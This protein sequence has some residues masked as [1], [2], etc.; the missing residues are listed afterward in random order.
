MLKSVPRNC[1]GW[2][3]TRASQGPGRGA[4]SLRSSPLWK[5]VAPSQPCLSLCLREGRPELSRREPRKGEWVPR[6][7]LRQLGARQA[8]RDGT[9][10]HPS[11]TTGEGGVADFAGW[12]SD[13]TVLEHSR[14]ILLLAPLPN[15]FMI[16]PRRFCL[17]GLSSLRTS[18][19]PHGD[20]PNN[21]LSSELRNAPLPAFCCPSLPA[22]GRP[23]SAA[24]APSKH[25][26]ITVM[27]YSKPFGGALNKV[28]R[29]KFDS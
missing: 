20:V 13:L 3:G 23:A 14:S 2:S 17:E 7:D 12:L 10:S 22:N 26:V 29:I 24:R 19:L 15:E 18:L 11:P 8:L 16:E 21:H 4:V 5:R 1:H 27:S 25:D 6:P 28:P 9:D